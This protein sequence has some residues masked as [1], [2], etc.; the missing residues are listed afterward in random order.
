MVD[1]ARLIRTIVLGA[2]WHE[3]LENIVVDEDLD[4]LGI[5]IV[6]LAEAFMNYLQSIKKFDFRIPARF[7][8]VASILLRMKCELLLEEEEKARRQEQ[9]LPEINLENIPQLSPP[10]VRKPIRK[11]TLS[12]LISALNKAMEFKEKKETKQVR[13]RRAVETL[14]EPEEDIELRISGIFSKISKA[15]EIKFSDLVPA[16]K[17]SEIVDTFMPLLYLCM[18]SKIYCDQPE[19]FSEIFIKVRE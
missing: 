17:R 16:W 2:D 4:P 5:D 19:M 10:V 12:E 7:I 9:K 18:R 1:E 8:L 11:V 14:I 6:K 13:L 15:G 3:V